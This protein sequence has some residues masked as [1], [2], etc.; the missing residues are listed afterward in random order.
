MLVMLKT[1]TNPCLSPPSLGKKSQF[2]A[3]VGVS[4]VRHWEAFGCFQVTNNNEGEGNTPQDKLQQ[5][6]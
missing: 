1:R 4:A 5:G 3:K 2:I 6:N